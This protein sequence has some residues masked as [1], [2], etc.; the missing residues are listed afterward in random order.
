MCWHQRSRTAF[1]I[2]RYR[3]AVDVL[4][5]RERRLADTE[6]EP[7][8]KKKPRSMRK[9]E[10]KSNVT[11]DITQT[12]KQK[13]GP[14]DK[15]DST[16][17]KKKKEIQCLDETRVVIEQVEPNS[18]TYIHASKVKLDKEQC[19]GVVMLCNY[20]EDGM[21]KCDEYFPTES[22]AYKY[23]GKMFVNNKKGEGGNPVVKSSGRPALQAV[24]MTIPDTSLEDPS[25]LCGLG[26]G[27]QHAGL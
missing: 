26:G 9:K 6:D 14:A 27:V 12:Q 13:R 25:V 8:Q 19:A 15:E 1:K 10:E 24:E 4:G 11:E 16:L 5:C 2:N 22:G 7:Q 20:Y 21:Q 18:N 23:Y 3:F 17:E